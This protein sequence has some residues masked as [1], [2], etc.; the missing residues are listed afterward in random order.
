MN[1]LGTA[2]ARG[3]LISRPFIA[4]LLALCLAVPAC[5]PRENTTS[6]LEEQTGQ[7]EF[8]SQMK[9]LVR[10]A[11]L[12][13]PVTQDLTPVSHTGVYPFA[14]PPFLSRRLRK[15]RF[16]AA[17]SCFGRPAS[18]GSGRSSPGTASSG[19]GR[20]S[21]WGLSAIHGSITTASSDWQRSMVCRLWLAR[22]PALLEPPRQLGGASAADDYNDYGDFV[23]ALAARYKG[24]IK[25]YQIWNEPNTVL[26]WAVRR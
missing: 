12:R 5:S 25:H 23:A 21:S 4:L 24:R 7:T 26:E 8:V 17:W 11:L 6:W 9:A 13:Q 16:V 15:R 14:R 19:R 18:F 20:G 22:L 10:L 2:L 3:P 1:N